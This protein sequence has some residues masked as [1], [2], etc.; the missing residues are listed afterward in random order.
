LAAVESVLSSDYNGNFEIIIVDDA[1]R[2]KVEDYITINPRIK[3]IR[4]D[5]NRGP[6]Y[7]RNAGAKISKGDILLFIDSDIYIR[8]N[9]LLVIDEGFK[10]EKMSALVGR[11]NTTCLY[12]DFF[13]N[14]YNL[15]IIKSSDDQK[16]DFGHAA[17][18]AIRKV[19]F[20]KAGGFDTKYRRA[21]VEDVEFGIRLFSL[22]YK[23]KVLNELSVVHDKKMTFWSLLINDF[24]RSAD[25]VEFILS[26]KQIKNIIQKR[27]F[28]Q[29]SI[30]Q[31]FPILLAPLFWMTMILG[32]TKHCYYFVAILFALLFVHLNRGSLL[33]IY[34]KKGLLFYLKSAGFYLIDLTFIFMGIITGLIVNLA[35]NFWHRL[36]CGYL[37]YLKYFFIKKSAVEITF[38]V[39]GK[40]NAACGYCFYSKELNLAKR[41]L[42]LMEIE[43]IFS[44][45]GPLFRVLISGGEPFLRPDLPEIIRIICI[46]SRPRHITI[47]TNG[48]M[49][50][51]IIAST[52]EILASCGKTVIN[53]GFSLSELNDKRDLLM[54]VEG[55]FNST[56]RTY[57][58]L[59]RLKDRFPN[60]MVGVIITQTPSNQSH[61]E[62]IYDFARN[63][64][65]ADNIAFVLMRNS[66]NQAEEAKID[67]AIYKRLVEKIKKDEYRGRFPF[68][69]LFVSRRNMVHDYVIKSYEKERYLLPCYA[70]MIR[71]VITPEGQVY[72]CETLMLKS[73]E[74]FKLGNL[75][76]C[77]YNIKQIYK[78]RKRNDICRY[79]RENKCHCRHECDL[80]T[81]ILFNPNPLLR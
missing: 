55:S 38:F 54:N 24:I 79:I 36:D 56:L 11:Y 45:F 29:N 58:R 64:L 51:L 81:N 28:N 65:K 35:S 40:C 44:S 37:S 13:S 76:D 78:G 18:Y 3:I 5:I 47:P 23:A 34:R 73:R 33:F 60:F 48:I 80:L 50:D 57:Y 75:R 31:L 62:E 68:W 6:A 10:E 7:S 72:P 2:R 16:F 22:G 69:R 71:F 15:R 61:I 17:I 26:L 46:Y 32:F 59:K 41:E 66:P 63:E 70:G 74:E 19:I 8:E 20:T 4:N 49:T 42:S 25:R 30:E 67:L 1:S 43:K 39:T 77:Y 14:Y 9:A 53:I 27:R 21:S 12:R 52:E